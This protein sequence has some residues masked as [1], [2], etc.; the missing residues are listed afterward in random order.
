[1]NSSKSHPSPSIA[2]NDDD[3]DD[4]NDVSSKSIYNVGNNHRP[5]SSEQRQQMNV[6]HG[7]G[8]FVTTANSFANLSLA[9]TLTEVC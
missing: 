5:L 2:R 8:Q 3:D 7:Y 4:N 6:T 9:S 1:M